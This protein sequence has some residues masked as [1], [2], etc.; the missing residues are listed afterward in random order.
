M[1]HV[2]GSLES[3]GVHGPVRVAAEIGDHLQHPRT[4]KSPQ[5]FRPRMLV[6]GLCHTPSLTD[7]ALHVFREL[8]HALPTRSDPDQ[9]SQLITSTTGD[10]HAISGIPLTRQPE[11]ARVEQDAMSFKVARAAARR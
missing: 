4:R 1:K 8:P 7:L 11:P 2:D 9:T 5:R 10:E 6:A 3:H